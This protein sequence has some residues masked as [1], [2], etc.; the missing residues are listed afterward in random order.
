MIK[1]CAKI[2][3]AFAIVFIP[4]GFFVS[5]GSGI[6]VQDSYYGNGVWRI[7]F[8]GQSDNGF[9]SLGATFSF[10]SSIIPHIP[11][12]PVSNFGTLHP[13]RLY[14]P[15]WMHSVSVNSFA[16]R[17]VIR[18]NFTA[19]ND[20]SSF[21][22]DGIAPVFSFFY[23]LGS[24]ITLEDICLDTIRI[25]NGSADND[26]LAVVGGASGLNI[27]PGPLAQFQILHWG[28]TS[29][30]NSVGYVAI[31]YMG[32]G[33]LARPEVQLTGSV[34]SWGAVRLAENY[35]IYANG[36]FAVA[37]DGISICLNTVE[38][39]PG[40]RS[41]T[42]VAIGTGLDNS[43]PSLPVEY[44]VFSGPFLEMDFPHNGAY[45]F[46]ELSSYLE[47][48]VTNTGDLPVLGFFVNMDEDY[49]AFDIYTV[50]GNILL[51]NE[52]AS[53][54]ISPVQNLGYGKF[55]A[56]VAIGG[57][58]VPSLYVYVSIKLVEDE[59]PK[60]PELPVLPLPPIPL[61]PV[62]LP[63]AVE[64]INKPDVGT[65]TTPPELCRHKPHDNGRYGVQE[66]FAQMNIEKILHTV[67]IIKYK[68]NPHMK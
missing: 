37:T 22:G 11:A 15:G 41:I 67:W 51:P 52:V 44:Y 54:I 35:R 58:G 43:V 36:V 1:T 21:N 16:G 34:L 48:E 7:T 46:M 23:T 20:A 9:S 12:S 17:T 19:L 68:F 29:F 3:V 47:I 4:V 60:P 66:Y 25:K 39:T 62:E 5:E 26:Y 31:N 38:L 32:F 13:L 45:N 24:G 49:N 61:P 65:H 18:A 30:P 27:S 28:H 33:R 2:I 6:F 55:T 8:Y 42:V 59:L 10:N 64:P 14:M 56:R 50:A 57:N 63:P 40:L 53:I